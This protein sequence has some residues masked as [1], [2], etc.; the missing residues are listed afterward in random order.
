MFLLNSSMVRL[1]RSIAGLNVHFA[2]HK[3]KWELLVLKT[4]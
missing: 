1:G 3:V 2:H 4:N